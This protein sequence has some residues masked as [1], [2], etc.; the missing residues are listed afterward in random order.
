MNRKNKLLIYLFLIF[1]LLLSAVSIKFYFLNNNS[2][3]PNSNLVYAN[4]E[5]NKNWSEQTQNLLDENLKESFDI[6]LKTENIRLNYNIPSEISTLDY[7]KYFSDEKAKYLYKFIKD[8]FYS[9]YTDMYIKLDFETK[10]KFKKGYEEYLK[11]NQNNIFNIE[12]YAEYKIDKVAIYYYEKFLKEL[13]KKPYDWQNIWK[14]F[15]TIAIEHK[16]RKDIY[17]IDP[18]FKKSLLFLTPAGKEIAKQNNIT[19]EQIE[20]EREEYQKILEQKKQEIAEQLDKWARQ[21][22][23]IE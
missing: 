5:T 4:I 6:L 20:K 16:A 1:F 12:R 18:D 19:E 23:I 14:E 15:R 17:M 11:E 2:S 3:L 21:N 10:Q 13:I 9:I 8:Y 22:G 7:E